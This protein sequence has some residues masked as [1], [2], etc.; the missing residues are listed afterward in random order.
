[1]DEPLRLLAA[2]SLA[3]A[4]AALEDVA[5]RPVEAVFGASGP[6]RARIERG[7]AWDVFASAD[8]DHPAVLHRNGVA[9]SPR[10]FCHNTLSL[11]LRPGLEGNDAT[12]LLKRPDLRLG[13]STP[14]NDP[15]G[16]YAVEALRGLDSVEPGAGDAAIARAR[17]LTG[18]PGLPAPP[19]GHNTYA[20][21][22]MSGATDLFLTYRTNARA[23]QGDTPALR[24]PCRPRPAPSPTAPV[25]WSNSPIRS[26]PSSPP[27]PGRDPALRHGARPDAG[28][29]ARQPTDEREFL[30]Q[31]YADLPEL[32][33]LTGQGG[34]ANLERVLAFSPT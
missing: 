33:T 11:I 13:I 22:V 19:E 14:G 23:A 12:A 29:A 26:E 8:T 25:V 3:K 32:G 31:P 21:L 34:E 5:G 17:Q 30:A 10:V 4:F 15:S 28:L 18:A 9:A 7:E 1:M 6:L 27:A 16:D 20:W 24:C 2:G